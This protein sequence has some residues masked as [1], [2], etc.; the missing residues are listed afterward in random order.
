MN[1]SICMA[2]HNGEKFL[3]QQID[4]I[5][6]QMG[7]QDEL[8]ISDDSSSDATLSILAS[9]HDARIKFL[10]TQ[11]FGT[12]AKNFEYVLTFSRHSVIFLADQDDVWHSQKIHEMKEALAGCDLVVCDCSIVDQELLPI[13]HSFFDLNRSRS[14]LF[15]NLV[16]NSFIGCCMAFRRSVLEKSFPFPAGISSH[17]Q[18]IGLVAERYFRVKF[19]PYVLV[20]HRRHPENYSS[21]GEGSENS[22]QK[23]IKLRLHLAK[24]LLAQ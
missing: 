16:K 1:V 4:S 22:F 10:G 18:W 21:T 12:P 19:I 23:K 14:G 17:D 8:L 9:Y 11:C 5:I 3:R 20:D 6:K 24:Q 15:K 2:T 13:H 7:P